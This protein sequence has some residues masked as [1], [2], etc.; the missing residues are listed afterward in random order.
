MD[1]PR[2]I[3][4]ERLLMRRWVASDRPAFAQMNADPRVMEHFPH[5]LT[6][7]ESDTLVD[8]IQT[9]FE[10]H[11]FGLWAVEVRDQVPFIGFVGLAVPT[12][13]AHF[14]PCVEI[15]WRVAASAWG[16]G[17]ATEAARATVEFAFGPA[18]LGE[19]V[20]FTVPENLRSRRVMER[21][22]MT[23]NPEDDFDH[24]LL[25]GRRRHVLYRLR[26]SDNRP[27]STFATLAPN[28]LRRSTN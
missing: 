9:H 4:T 16:H 23:H 21:I 2:E 7:A 14:T 28:A 6:R 20:S 19:L 22:G 3:M 26:A 8:R 12:F 10:R 17:F 25:P 11:G 13:E 27:Y 24:P 18:G 15:G 1:L 5:L